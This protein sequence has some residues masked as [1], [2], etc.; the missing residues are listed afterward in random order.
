MN[1]IGF[2]QTEATVVQEEGTHNIKTV[3]VVVIARFQF[4]LKSLQEIVY[5]NRCTRTYILRLKNTCS[6]YSMWLSTAVP[7]TPN[8]NIYPC[9]FRL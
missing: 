9:S 5:S 1:D 8:K 3:P 6:L 2:P 4:E 7:K